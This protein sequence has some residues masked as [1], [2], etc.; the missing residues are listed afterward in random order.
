MGNHSLSYRGLSGQYSYGAASRGFFS[1]ARVGVL[2][3]T[4]VS[5]LDDRMGCDSVR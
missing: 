1:A 2:G 5:D 3:E 4:A